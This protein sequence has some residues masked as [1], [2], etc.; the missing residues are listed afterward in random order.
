MMVHVD[1]M[2][3]IAGAEGEESFLG[4]QQGIHTGFGNEWIRIG[5]AKMFSDG[6]L[7]GRTAAVYQPFETSPGNIGFFVVEEQW[8][9][10]KIMKL[11]RSGWQIAIHA[12]GDRAVDLVVDGYEAA[13]KA[14]PDANRRHRVEHAGIASPA[15]LDRMAR[16]GILGIPQ[17]H[18]IGRTGD[19]YITNL[20]RKRARWCYPQRAYLERGMVLPG[21]SDR[22]VVPGAPLLGMHDAVNQRTA[23]GQPYVPEEAITV[24]E[25][26]RA[27]TLGSAFTSHEERR[28]GS[29]EPGKLADLTVLEEDLTAILPEAIAGVRVLATM[30]D[31]RFRYV[32]PEAEALG[33]AISR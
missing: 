9:L 22:P 28:K 18:F 14:A 23:S 8:L 25:A 2:K 10:E 5:P 33:N 24:E 20:G 6:S 3:E 19:G 12:I 1:Y 32:H 30:V 17:Q 29:L 26:L 31:G 13:L 15:T 7:I 16:L 11:H 21:S 4:L 27:Y